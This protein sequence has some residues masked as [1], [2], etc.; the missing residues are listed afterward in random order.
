MASENFEGIF[1]SYRILS[2]LNCKIMRCDSLVVTSTV[3][4]S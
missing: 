4:F 3:F 2:T 1:H